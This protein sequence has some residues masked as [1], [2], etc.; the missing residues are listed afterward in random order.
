MNCW[1]VNLSFLITELFPLHVLCLQLRLHASGCLWKLF[2]FS[3]H[4]WF[5]SAVSLFDWLLMQTSP[6]RHQQSTPAQINDIH[7]YATSFAVSLFKALWGEEVGGLVP[8]S[9]LTY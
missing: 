1:K 4:I 9:D 3:L 6:H 7:A 8:D 5:D 2:A